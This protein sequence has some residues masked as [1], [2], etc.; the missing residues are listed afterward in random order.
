MT[1]IPG[2]TVEMTRISESRSSVPTMTVASTFSQGRLI[3]GPRTALSLQSRTAKT[4]VLG[5][6]IPASACTAVV[7]S[8]NGA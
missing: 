3:H 7:I 1:S 8:P 4:V 6:R 2:A 5:K